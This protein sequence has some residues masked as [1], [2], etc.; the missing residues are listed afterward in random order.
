[1]V[2]VVSEDPEF[3]GVRGLVSDVLGRFRDWS[4]HDV[5]VSGPA[6]MV[7]RTVTN[8]QELCV[9]A[10]RIHYDAPDR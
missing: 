5:Y 4:G 3:D 1:M 9:P 10:E 6:G 8:L 7:S 2:P